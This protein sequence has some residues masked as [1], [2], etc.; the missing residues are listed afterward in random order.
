MI[1]MKK[2]GI[3]LLLTLLTTTSPSWAL[4]HSPIAESAVFSAIVQIKTLGLDEDG[5]QTPGYCN[6]TFITS[7]KLVTAAHCVLDA[8]ALNSY[9]VGIIAGH[10]IYAKT[11]D[12]TVRRVGYRPTNEMKMKAQFLIP[13]TLS[14]KFKVSKGKTSIGPTEDF[15][16]IVLES[17][18]PT[19]EV[20]QP[21]PLIGADEV[22]PVE[23]NLKTY[24]PSVI[25]INPFSNLGNTDS[26]RGAQ[27]DKIEFSSGHFQSTSIAR[28][29][30][31]DS[32]APLLVRI[33]TQWKVI[34]VV[35]GL[36]KTIFS[37]WDAYAPVDLSLN[38]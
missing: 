33:G 32:G 30:E 22:V 9:E 31:G 8:M 34:G 17:A 12:G 11:P 27:L 19:T 13:R 16:V 1:P 37:N 36:V 20:I 24:M 28:V 10:Y 4:T 38:Q 18:P 29:E 35:K 26:K 3:F 14:E 15:A 23:G 25:T 7:T 2:L 6:A 21:L 5:Q